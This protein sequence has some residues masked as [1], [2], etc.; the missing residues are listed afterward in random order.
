MYIGLALNLFKYSI[1]CKKCKGEKTMKEKKK[2]VWEIKRGMR[3]G[4]PVILHGEGDKAVRMP[5]RSRAM[6]CA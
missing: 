4:E 2:F 6:L 1:R 3:H 5:P